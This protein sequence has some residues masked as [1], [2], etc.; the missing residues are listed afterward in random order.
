[1]NKPDTP[2]I[3]MTT[4]TMVNVRGI[5]PRARRSRDCSV[6]TAWAID[7]ETVVDGTG[8]A[9]GAGFPNPAEPYPLL[10]AFE[11]GDE[12]GGGGVDVPTLTASLLVLF[13]MMSP[14][15]LYSFFSFYEAVRFALVPSTIP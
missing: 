10:G 3:K 2:P 6:T 13:G 15:T 7:E 11:I 9:V 5:F 8:A 1:M 14:C 4:P 12:D